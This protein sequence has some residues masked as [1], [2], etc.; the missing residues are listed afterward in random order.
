M[1]KRIYVHIGLCAAAMVLIGSF[2][3]LFTSG[4]SSRAGLPGAPGNATAQVAS[5]PQPGTVLA[6]ARAAH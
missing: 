3:V 6:V 5:S 1:S 4:N 2:A